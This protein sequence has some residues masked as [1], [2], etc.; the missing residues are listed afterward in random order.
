MLLLKDIC[1]R[2]V[3][4]LP[5]AKK[6]VYDAPEVVLQVCWLVDCKRKGAEMLA[7]VVSKACNLSEVGPVGPTLPVAP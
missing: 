2:G 1:W 5:M 3:L 4:E 7:I 6:L